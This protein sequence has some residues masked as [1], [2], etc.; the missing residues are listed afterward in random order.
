MTTSTN[1]RPWWATAVVYQLYVRSFADANSDGIGDIAG[2]RSR[3][4]Y[5]NALGV[6]AIWL[7]PCYPSPQH[8]HGYDISDFFD[9]E[10]EYGTL[11]DFD[12][13]VADARQHGIK[14]LMDVVSNHCSWDHP[15]FKEAVAA[16]RGSGERGRF[17]F[18]DGK[19]DN[20]DEPPNN[21]VS[22]FGGSTW[23]RVTEPDG[24][25]GQWYLHVFAS[26]QPD[27]NWFHPDVAQHFDDMLR[28][29]F[30]RGVEGFRAD[31]VVVLGKTEGLP[32]YDSTTPQPRE[33]GSNNP[34]YMF[35]PSGHR[36]WKRWRS[37][38][39][40]YQ[41]EHPERELFI[42]AEAYTPG[43]PDL[44]QQYVNPH[45][46]HQSFAFDLLL[47]PWVA[48]N[49]R[50]AMSMFI[51]TLLPRGLFPAWTLNNHDA[52]R[53]VTRF[54]RA[55]AAD[56]ASYTGD[57][58]INST[59]LVDLGVGTRRA[60]AAV[61]LMLALPGSAYLYMGEELGLPEVLDLPDD[62]RQDPIFLRTSGRDIGRDGC[63][64]PMAWTRDPGTLFGFCAEARDQPAWMPQPAGWGDYAADSQG[65]AVDSVLGLY[66]AAIASRKAWLSSDVVVW[67]DVGDPVLLAFTRDNV[68]VVTNFSG[69]ARPL[70]VG[71]VAGRTVVLSSEFGH[72]DSSV[73]PG[74]TTVWLR[75]RPG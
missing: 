60:R 29:W 37:V 28:F 72:D 39:D 22:I 4:G 44:L 61:S 35:H 31:A 65:T 74:D 13:L 67:E 54:G 17:Y 1:H 26:Q 20:G 53:C 11:A 51:D 73:V 27:M 55:D 64:V 34:H 43:N 19:G 75:V 12:A 47:S 69:E 66:R 24:S 23:T 63:R 16:G 45:E 41:V 68:L 32:D 71:L 30:D 21:W 50:A 58:L 57:N 15:W 14:I 59:A 33:I 7:N 2:I 5:L 6:D 36:A 52:Q 25:P 8:D 70:P 9:I 62:A 46:F 56:P 38:V 3:L 40:Q 48:A 18:R 10:P 42:V 49:F